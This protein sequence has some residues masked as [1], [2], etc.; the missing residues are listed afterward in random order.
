MSGKKPPRK[1]KRTDVSRL[2]IEIT[3]RGKVE[4]DGEGWKPPTRAATHEIKYDPPGMEWKEDKL[5]K[6]HL[7]LACERILTI[8]GL[9]EP[10]TFVRLMEFLGADEPGQEYSFHHRCF[11]FLLALI[12]TERG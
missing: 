11:L 12:L 8:E 2:D 3:P 5:E 10:I 4:N 9:V 7:M 6:I 1:L